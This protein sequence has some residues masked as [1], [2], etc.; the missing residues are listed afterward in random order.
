MEGTC[1]LR[2]VQSWTSPRLSAP[3]PGG[4]AFYRYRGGREYPL[5]NA[6]DES[7]V[8]ADGQPPSR[9]DPVLLER[10]LEFLRPKPDGRYVDATLG[11]AGHAAAILEHSEGGSLLGFDRDPL[12]CSLATKRL[13]SFGARATV[14]HRSY[15]E[16]DLGLSDLGWDSVDGIVADLGLSS[17]QL[18]DL[19][20]G[21]SFRGDGA[22]DMRF[23]TTEGATASELVN[24]LEEAELAQIIYRFGEER[25]SRAIARRIVAERPIET[26]SQ[27]R[28]IVHSS[29]GHRTRSRHRRAIDP[30]TRTFQALRIAVNDELQRLETFLSIVPRR[31]APSGRLA[32]LSYH[33]LED[34]IVKW[35]F[36]D[37][38]AEGSSPSEDSSR[39]E[40]LTKKPIIADEA[41]VA[42]NPRARSAK[43]RVLER[44]R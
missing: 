44:L 2:R 5:A 18:D 41:E 42:K 23:D 1:D 39:F 17:L 10:I 24:H 14:C 43:L 3:L 31:L 4:R 30:A 20:R 13:A 34:R 35:A 37:L 27:L 40:I 6:N 22:L 36:R 19:S 16:L 33:S 28:R 29:Y 21:F 9:H 38:V 8:G 15:E 26:A 25:R 7:S 12:A 11:G 32:I